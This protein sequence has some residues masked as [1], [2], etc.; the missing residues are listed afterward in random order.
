MYSEQKRETKKSNPIKTL[1]NIATI[2]TTA[3]TCLRLVLMGIV[4]IETAII[5]TLAVLIFLALGKSVA[6]IVLACIALIFFVLLYSGGTSEGLYSLMGSMITLI[7]ILIGI[8]I[9][10]RGAFRGK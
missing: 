7:C 6:K 3:I 9:M 5:I 2:V 4:S 8:Y 10:L 1:V